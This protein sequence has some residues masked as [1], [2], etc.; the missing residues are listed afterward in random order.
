MPE[1]VTVATARLLSLIAWATDHPGT[2]REELAAHFG[3]SLRQIDR[4]VETLGSVSDHDLAG[5]MPV[6]ID[7]AAWYGD[8]DEQGTEGVRDAASVRRLFVRPVHATVLPPKL[9]GREILGMLV[10]LRAI[11][12]LLHGQ[13]EA[14]LP[15]IAADLLAMGPAELTEDAAALA[16]IPVRVH[17]DDEDVL[18]DIRDALDDSVRLSFSY[19]DADGVPTRRSVDPLALA[20]TAQTWHLVAHDLDADDTRRFRVDRM[21][22]VRVGDEPATHELDPA[23][24]ADE[25][26]TDGA[27]ELVSVTVSRGAAW[28]AD[29][30]PGRVTRH[31]DDTLTIQLNTWSPGWIEALLIDISPHLLAVDPP[32]WAERA[33][34]RANV[35][36][37][38]WEDPA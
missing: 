19:L 3:R 18:D 5:R 31:P 34:E 28:L 38:N 27:A 9:T 32:E 37:V 2:S 33:A 29:E 22:E 15:R 24:S 26:A 30:F 11:A 6:E 4:D 23:A 14:R 13:E 10:S 35:A 1:N 21:Q 36:L 25:T 8:D 17:E 12:P 20:Q 7:W 16:Q